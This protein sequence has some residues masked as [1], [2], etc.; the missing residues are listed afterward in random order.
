MA[1]VYAF[2]AARYASTSGS[3]RFR[4]QKYSSTLVSP[5]IVLARGTARATGGSSLGD[6]VRG[7]IVP[8]VD[9]PGGGASEGS[10]RLGLFDIVALSVLG[11]REDPDGAFGRSA[12]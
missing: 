2:S 8:T 12:A 1:S 11:S 9:A 7:E 5:W 10:V 6:R 4:S 3:S